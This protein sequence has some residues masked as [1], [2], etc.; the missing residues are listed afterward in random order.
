MK[1][2]E[3]VP[4]LALVLVL[5]AGLLGVMPAA[6]VDAQG[7]IHVTVND[8]DTARFPQVVA[9]VTVADDSGHAIVELARSAFSLSED[10]TP[11]AGFDL[12]AMQNAGE[13]ILLALA[14]DTS[15]SMQG[16]ALRNTQA[17]AAQL[18]RDLGPADKVAVL[19]FADVVRTEL[20][21]STDKE[22]AVAAIESLRAGGKTALH[23]AILHGVGLLASQPRGRKALVILTDG[24]DVGSQATMEQ[25]IQS[26]QAAGV[27]VYAIG[28]GGSIKP[29]V[30][31]E[32]A[33][34]TGGHFYRTPSSDEVD[35]SFEAVARLLRHQYVLSYESSLLAD[36]AEHTLG[37]TVEIEGVAPASDQATFVAEPGEVRVT[38]RALADGDTV[39]GQVSLKPDV[40]APGEVVQVEYLL[41][42]EL[43]K[44]ATVGDMGYEWDASAV[45]LGAHTLTVRA[46]DRAGNVGETSLTLNVV[47]AVV[48]DLVRPTGERPVGARVPVEVAITALAG[49]AQVQFE[50]D[51]ATVATVTTPPWGFTWDTSA[52][53]VTTHTLS[54][55]AYDVAGQSARA[56]R[57]LW[58]GMRLG[59][60]G[61][62][63]GD[64]VGGSWSLEPTIV[65]PAAPTQVEYLL[66]DIALATTPGDDPGYEWDASAAT[67]GEHT[68]AM[69]VVDAEGNTGRLDLSVTVT[70]PLAVALVSPPEKDLQS[71][72]RE[73]EVEAEVFALQEVDRV[74]FLVD[75]QVIE[76]VRAEPYGFS[77]DTTGFATGK[78]TL[79][80]TVHDVKNQTDTT[81]LEVWVAF[82]GSSWGI[83]AVLALLIVGVGVVV[84][85]ARRRRRNM[86]T[87]PAEPA[88]PAAG[89]PVSRPVAGPGPTPD[90][91]RA[92]AWLVVEAGPEA[93]RRWPVSPGETSLGRTRSLNDVV[94][95]SSTAS[96]QHAVIRTGAEGCVYYDLKTTNPSLINDELMVGSHEL[97]EGDRIRIGDVILRFTKE[98]SR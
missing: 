94:I 20:E 67:P 44:K 19:S 56:S 21:F 38:M 72:G 47:E 58:V 48:V 88:G 79:S 30:L 73:V 97:A 77:W 10:G 9:Y 23:D 1:R 91:G 15:G 40:D 59:L 26:A 83:W 49:V 45:P 3:I 32:L 27:S 66:D 92:A 85:L 51:G 33:L 82:R 28:F 22:A 4:A 89:P 78:H 55:A 64:L 5:L 6:R 84:P 71:L 12:A 17:A 53:K 11:V 93:G 57:E 95:S 86:A 75:G 50:V 80:A 34:D 90:A 61:L 39:G 35:E 63:D 36:A 87:A 25:A 43:L 37:V 7:Q 29:A 2:Y 69:R 41:D 24:E 62:A 8:V 74:E 16:N 60:Q 42:G 96:R 65:A 18:V 98:G 31:R 68:L 70:E 81:S 76:T 46:T 14:L 13:P 54:V 52:L